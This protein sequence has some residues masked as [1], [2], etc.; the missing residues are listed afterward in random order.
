M[1]AGSQSSMIRTGLTGTSELRQDQ[2]VLQ[3]NLENIVNLIF[4]NFGLNG[5][6]SQLGNLGA[7]NTPIP[8]TASLLVLLTFVVFALFLYSKSDIRG[9]ISMISISIVL[10]VLPL[11][12]LQ[13]DHMFVG[14]WVQ[15]RYILPLLYLLIGFGVVCS[16]KIELPKD[17]QM[18]AVLALTLA[19]SLCLHATI[20]RYIS[21]YTSDF[22]TGFFLLDRHISWW[23]NFGPSPFFTWAVGSIAFGLFA[24]IA[25]SSLKDSSTEI[26]RGASKRFS[27]KLSDSLSS[28]N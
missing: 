23:S 2:G 25:I 21:D 11:W 12:V 24:A 20:R 5:S 13:I 19:H 8:P 18:I 28:I 3:Y 26:N 22:G 16:A 1:R 17:L 10:V 4:G 9:K 14:F 27:K 7:F 15:P 6:R